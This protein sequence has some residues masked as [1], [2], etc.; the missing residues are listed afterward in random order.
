MHRFFFALFLGVAALLHGCSSSNQSVPPAEPRADIVAAVNGQNLLFQDLQREYSRTSG[1]ADEPVEDTLAAYEDFLERYVDYRLKVLEAE[2]A[3]M[4]KDPETVRE[5]DGYRRQYARPYLLDQTVIDPI[6]KELYARE[7]A[8]VDVSHILIQIEGR[9]PADTLAAYQKLAAIADSI[10]AGASFADMAARHSSDPSAGDSERGPGNRGRLGYITGG[11]TVKPFED[12]AYETPV[13]SISKIVRTRF[14]YHLIMAHNARETPG[15][16]RIAH[17]MI[18]PRGQTSADSAA[19][20][21]RLDS[22][23]TKLE[24]GADYGAL[25]AAY[26]DDQQSGENGGDLGF[27]KFGSQFVPEMKEVAFSLDEVGSVSDPVQTRFGFHLIKLL[28]KKDFP[29]IDEKYEELKTKASR[30]PDATFR[31]WAF[32]DS[33]LTVRNAMVDTL[34]LDEYLEGYDADSLLNLEVY[35]AAWDTLLFASIADSMYTLTEFVA[36]SPWNRFTEVLLLDDAGVRRSVSTEFMRARAIEYEMA[37]LELTDEEFART[38]REFRNGILL[39]SLMEDSVWTA[40]AEDTSAIEALYAEDPDAYRFPD[41]TIV[42]SV[43]SRSVDLVEAGVILLAEG[44]DVDAVIDSLNAAGALDI[45]TTLIAEAS[46]SIYDRALSLPSGN[47][48]DP[49]VYNNGHIALQNAGA[50]PAR[51]KKVDEARAEL[52]NA[53]QGRLEER[54]VSRLRAKYRAVTYP[55]RLPAFLA[56]HG[57]DMPTAIQ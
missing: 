38:L 20:L 25:A 10:S 39:F 54:L 1:L 51:S 30:T 40:A 8:A 26:S 19:A 17:I 28:E 48:T 15:D 43:Y 45:D 31:E 18:S 4:D 3:G 5:I 57:S 49:I 56:E 16:V 27:I 35:P 42:V 33:M 53:L 13:G 6:V 21:A 37:A 55:E 50:E 11:V 52:V 12:A 36:N 41:R 7:A 14:G 32:A 22:V 46:N 23:V 2:A 24:G 34:L 44:L 47:F 29:S 9:S